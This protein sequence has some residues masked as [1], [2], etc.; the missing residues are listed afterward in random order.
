ML[1]SIEGNIGSGKSTIINYLKNYQK[2]N[3]NIVFVDEPV[4]EWLNIKI[5]NKNALELFYENQKEN[6]FW[7][8]ILA[9]ITRLRN[10]LEVIENNQNKIIICERSIYTDKYV[11][12]KM[13]YE[14]G[15]IKEIEWKTYSYWFDT[16]KSKTSLD[17]IIYV[18]TEPTECYNRII[19][20]NRQEEINK[21][22]KEYLTLCHNKHLE[23]FDIINSRITTIN[24][25]QSIENIYK[26]MDGIINS[27]IEENNNQ[28]K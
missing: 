19:K 15:F 5:D 4:S 21:I 1:V 9:Y 11:F 16:F 7:F 18:N 22:S 26:S 6:S 17:L 14:S 25:H 13:L 27:L 12:A 8:Q 24:G 23:W 2:N 3:S 10:L 28:I 20:R